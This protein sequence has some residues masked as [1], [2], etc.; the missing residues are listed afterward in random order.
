MK[1]R[2]KSVVV[3]LGIAVAGIVG[4]SAASLG[5][6]SQSLGADAK[7][8]AAC[9]SA[10]TASYTSTYNATSQDY[11]VTGVKL[12]NV[13][14]ACNTLAYSVTLDGATIADVQATG[15]VLLTNVVAGSGEFTASFTGVAAKDVGNLAVVISG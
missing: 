1:I 7:V 12:S 10:I 13:L 14:T 8:V 11:Q 5:L 15:T 9:D 4:A 6:T 2:N 3:L